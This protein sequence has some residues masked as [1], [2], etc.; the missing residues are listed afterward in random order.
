MD[1]AGK[2]ILVVG[3][4]GV[5]GSLI[6]QRLVDAGA[7]VLATCSSNESA[8][9]IPDSV[10]LKLLLDLREPQ[11][12]ETLGTYLNASKQLDGIVIAS[13]R[14]GFGAAV[15]TNAADA[16]MLMQINH[17]GPVGL[18]SMLSENLGRSAEPFVA[19]ITGVVAE[20]V[21]PGM[22]AYTASKTAFSTWL[23]AL[24]QEHGSFLVVDARPGHTETG[25]AARPLFGE[26]PKF[27]KGMDPNRVVDVLLAAIAHRKPEV[28]SSDF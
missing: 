5:F 9:R 2:T 8:V 1:F 25:L 11:S 14:V 16:Q 4:S 21:F 28:A 18:I 6:A 13:G 22:A 19:A 24:R 26:A 17:S 23:S 27:G 15:Q 12:I 10:A 7:T 20:K 3:A